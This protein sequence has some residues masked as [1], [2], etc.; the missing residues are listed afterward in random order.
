MSSLDQPLLIANSNYHVGQQMSIR[1]A[2]EQGYF[3]E[4]GFASYVHDWRGLLPGPLER[5]GLAL[6]MKEHGVDIATAVDVGSALYQRLRGA[7]LFIVGGWRYNPASSR[8]FGG[9]HV[10]ALAQ[11]RGKRI[12]TREAGDLSQRFVARQ[13]R[14]VGIDPDR[15]IEWLYNRAFAYGHDAAHL[16]LLRQ[17]HVEA[18]LSQPPHARVLE[19]EGYP[20]L[21]D[22]WQVYGG[23]RV[24]KVVVA[25][26]RT[27]ER[28]AD[29]LTAFLRANVRAFWF[30]RDLANMPYLQDLEVR[31]RGRSHNDDEQRVRMLNRVEKVEGWALPISGGI[32]RQA[33]AQI[34]DE[35]VAAGELERPLAVDDVLHDG[36]AAAAYA[37]LTSRPALQAAHQRALAAVER[38]G[39]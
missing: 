9:K 24:D 36:P 31:L 6:I 4:E 37:E 33:V 7:D 39:Y 29:E 35:L 5:E 34:V 1:V 21:L 28:R 20:V 19:E 27:V 15:E 18:M 12:G 17:G 16:D 38:W 23:A 13:L 26:G 11:L 14:R 32:T 25:T 30:M 2:E 10:T 22:P 3:R 8:L